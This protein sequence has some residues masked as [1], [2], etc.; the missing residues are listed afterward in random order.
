MKALKVL[1]FDVGYTLINEDEVWHRRCIEQAE[2]D[3][4]KA[5]GLT[6]EQIYEEIVQA[7]LMHLPQYR[8][9]IRKFGFRNPAPYR[10]EFERLYE[11]AVPAL[12]SL[13]EKY[14][15]GIIAN[16]TDGLQQRLR[17]LGVDKYFRYVISSWDCG[18]MKPDPEIF[19]IA[20]KRA[21]CAPEE[22]MMVGD[23]LDNDIRPAKG[24]GFRTTWIKK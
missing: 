22:A 1:F 20:L 5:L 3:E 6:P 16:Q 8:T 7:S 10:H 19:R 23:R 4:A 15:L 17:N 9:V 24:L 18:V 13:A 11:D 12:E 21:E 14:Q 2:S